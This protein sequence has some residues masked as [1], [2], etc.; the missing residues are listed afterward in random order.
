MFK[1]I[2]QKWYSLY[3]TGIPTLKVAVGSSYT[4]GQPTVT[5]PLLI[6]NPSGIHYG[7]SPL[8][9]APGSPIGLWY[10]V[11]MVYTGRLVSP[12]YDSLQALEEA[13]L[14]CFQ[15]DACRNEVWQHSEVSDAKTEVGGE[16][17]TGVWHVAMYVRRSR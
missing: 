13:Y 1:S 17:V 8:G 3:Q 12:H 4:H 16:V 7:E 5:A 11:E 6:V 2:L 15:A 9:V 10:E 14:L